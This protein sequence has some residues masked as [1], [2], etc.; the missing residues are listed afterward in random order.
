M[1]IVE[2]PDFYLS[3]AVTGHGAF[4]EYLHKIG[5]RTTLKCPCGADVQTPEHVFRYCQRYEC[6]RPANWGEGLAAAEIRQYLIDAMKVLWNAEKEEERT[7]IN[8]VR[9]ASHRPSRRLRL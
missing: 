8:R 3:Q 1:D 6:N 2:R 9:R 7:G 4:G 5:K